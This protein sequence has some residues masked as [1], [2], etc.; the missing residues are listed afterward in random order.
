MLTFFI[1]VGVFEFYRQKTV[2]TQKIMFS[3]RK[4]IGK[5]ESDRL[6]VSEE[7]R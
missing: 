2:N 4:K 5:K 7:K 3:F 6:E 1:G